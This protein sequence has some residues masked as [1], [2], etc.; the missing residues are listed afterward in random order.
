MV[1]WAYSKSVVVGPRRGYKRDLFGSITNRLLICSFIFIEW[2][3]CARFRI[4]GGGK[5]KETRKILG[6]IAWVLNWIESKEEYIWERKMHLIFSEDV[7]F[8][9]G[10]MHKVRGVKQDLL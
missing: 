4:G 9:E 7:R 5:G 10:G 6:F 8:T 2:F 3:L 1:I